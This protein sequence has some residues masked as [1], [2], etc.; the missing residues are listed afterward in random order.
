MQSERNEFEPR[1]C[2]TGQAF[3][4]RFSESA[5]VEWELLLGYW[6]SIALIVAAFLSGKVIVDRLAVRIVEFC[7]LGLLPVMIWCCILPLQR[8]HAIDQSFFRV[9]SKAYRRDGD[10]KGSTKSR[11]LP[12]K[13]SLD[14][15][16][17]YFFNCAHNY[18]R[19]LS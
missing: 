17:N 5:Q 13:P 9:L 18:R 7:V 3:A 12:F 16:P 11:Q 2:R 19:D 1:I 14:R 10:R 6:G 4:G 8:K 15:R